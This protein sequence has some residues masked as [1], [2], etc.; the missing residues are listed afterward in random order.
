MRPARQL[1][2]LVTQQDDDL[3]QITRGRLKNLGFGI[4]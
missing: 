3:K 1:K 2:S 4:T